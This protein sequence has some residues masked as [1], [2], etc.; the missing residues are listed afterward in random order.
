MPQPH[1][2]SRNFHLGEIVMTKA[3]AKER[4]KGNAEKK[5]KKRLAN[6]EHPD[7]NTAQPGRFDPNTL[8]IKSPQSKKNANNFSGIRRGAARSG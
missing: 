4:A 1:N 2:T 3:R 5:A 7:A 8:S 6:A